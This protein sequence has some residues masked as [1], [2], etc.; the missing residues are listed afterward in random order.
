MH[1]AVGQTS[2]QP[3]DIPKSHANNLWH[4]RFF[5]FA[6]DNK[7]GEQNAVSFYTKS[8][9]KADMPTHW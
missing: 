9:R 1:I 8:L 6:L 2:H 4:H 3:D 7:G 5:P